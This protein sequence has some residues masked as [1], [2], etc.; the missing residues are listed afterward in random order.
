MLGAAGAPLAVAELGD[1]AENAGPGAAARG[2]HGGE[3]VH[4]KHQ[5]DIERHGLHKIQL[6]ALAVGV[7]PLVQVALH[8]AVRVGDDFA[9]LLPGEAQDRCGV[10]H[11]FQK[12]QDQLLAVSPADEV[13][14]GTL[15][16]HPVGVERGENAPESHL[17]AGGGGADLPCKDF[18]VRVAGSAQKTQTDQIGLPFEDLFDDDGVGGLGVGL[19][20][21]DA[22]V[23]LHFEHGGE[24]HDAQGRK[25]HDLEIAVGGAG[26]LLDGVELGVA[27]VDQND[28]RH[29]LYYITISSIMI[30]RNA[31]LTGVLLLA[32]CG[33]GKLLIA[34]RI[35]VSFDPDVTEAAG[36]R[37]I[38][39]N[40]LVRVHGSGRALRRG[41]P[42]ARAPQTHPRSGKRQAVL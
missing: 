40:G 41:R 4:G 17:D 39:N 20:E 7:G 36:A 1:V 12:V 31:L 33:G 37:I 16:L 15:E 35:M 6:Q 32:G 29:E 14:L 30:V 25:T 5:G 24:G 8:G 13:D 18:S 42:V 34:G 11:V 23:A 27:D 38:E 3:A 9:V 22:F 10:L 2:L 28:F 21:H 19:V 26:T